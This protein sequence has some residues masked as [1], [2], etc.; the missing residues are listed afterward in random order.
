MILGCIALSSNVLLSSDYTTI[1]SFSPCHP[2][3]SF[4]GVNELFIPLLLLE[5]TMS[6]TLIQED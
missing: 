4:K 1:T 5:I 3:E 6:R 2:S